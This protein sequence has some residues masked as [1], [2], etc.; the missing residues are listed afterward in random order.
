M[1]QALYETA[2]ETLGRDAVVDLV[3]L[4]GYYTLISMT[5][6]VFEVEP[7]EAGRLPVF[8]GAADA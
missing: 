4:A 8:G 1:P 7:Q 2:I 5:L 3:G 6:N